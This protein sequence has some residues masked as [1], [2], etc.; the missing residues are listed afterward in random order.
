MLFWRASDYPLVEWTWLI[1]V[2]V[3]RD[4]FIAKIR[5]ILIHTD[6]TFSAV[7]SDPTELQS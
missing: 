2:E 7:L 6:M 5:K 4:I 3:F 1:F